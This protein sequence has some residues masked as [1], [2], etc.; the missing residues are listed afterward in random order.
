VIGSREELEKNAIEGFEEFTGH[1]PHRPWIDKV[2]IPCPVCGEKA[3]RIA[4]VGNPWLDAGIISFS[5]LIDPKMG[6]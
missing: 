6:R 1:T 5:T 4:D 3:G 2:K